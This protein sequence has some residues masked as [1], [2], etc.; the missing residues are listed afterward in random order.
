[1]DP[2]Q[3]SH[4]QRDFGVL[5]DEHV[6]G[7]DDEAHIMI[8][9]VSQ[10]GDYNNLDLISNEKKFGKRAQAIIN[11][12]KT[13]QKRTSSRPSFLN[14]EEARLWDMLEIFGLDYWELDHPNAH[15]WSNSIQR[16]EQWVHYCIAVMERSHGNESV[17][18]L[19]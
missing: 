6:N 18:C 7:K 13:R 14:Q 16:V 5:V 9:E 15:N 17:I 8:Y 4:D 10:F 19:L 12:L 2:N 11:K 3:D 1:M